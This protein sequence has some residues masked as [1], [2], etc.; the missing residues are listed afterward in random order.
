MK[1]LLAATAAYLTK[2]PSLAIL[3]AF[4]LIT[5]SVALSDPSIENLYFDLDLTVIA[6]RQ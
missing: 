4:G 5:T 3:L 2:H 1:Q 6:S